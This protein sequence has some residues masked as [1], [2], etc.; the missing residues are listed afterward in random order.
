MPYT[1][2]TVAAGSLWSWAVAADTTSDLE[3]D[4]LQTAIWATLARLQ[5]DGVGGKTSH[6]HGRLKT[7]VAEG[8]PYRP[9]RAKLD[10]DERGDAVEVDG[11]SPG[12]LFRKHV[13]ARSAAIATFLRTDTLPSDAKAP[14]EKKPKGKKSKEVEE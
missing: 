6:D 9:L 4:M 7:I 8:L 13:S 12:G 5:S 1:Y 10:E 3:V 11:H 2:E 14:A